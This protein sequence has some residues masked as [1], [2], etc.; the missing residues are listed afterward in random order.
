MKRKKLTV[1]DLVKFIETHSPGKSLDDWSHSLNMTRPALIQRLARAK[2]LNNKTIERAYFDIYSHL[3]W[4]D[5]DSAAEVLRQ[6]KDGK[7][8]GSPLAVSSDSSNTHTDTFYLLEWEN[9][10]KHQK[11]FSS[12]LKAV[13]YKNLISEILSSNI[14]SCITELILS[15]VV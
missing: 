12:K 1:E 5:A 13:E 14:V 4:G 9:G 6:V 11:L 2:L 8:D 15:D 10:K 7:Y 3:K